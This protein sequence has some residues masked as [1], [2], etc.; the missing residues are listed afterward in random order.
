MA[1]KLIKK[2]FKKIY[3]KQQPENPHIDTVKTNC[4]KKTKQTKNYYYY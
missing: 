2:T 3:K 1:D 4:S